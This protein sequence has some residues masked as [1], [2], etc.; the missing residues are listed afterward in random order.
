MSFSEPIRSNHN[1]QCW[2]ATVDDIL[3]KKKKTYQNHGK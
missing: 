1:K 2:S 3:L